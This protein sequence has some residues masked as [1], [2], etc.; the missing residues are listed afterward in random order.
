MTIFSL[1]V[2]QQASLSSLDGLRRLAMCYR[3]IASSRFPAVDLIHSMEAYPCGLVGSWLAQKQGCPHA[4]TTHGT[5]GVIWHQKVV[6]RLAYQ[7]V[8]KKTA[9]LCPVSNGTA[10]M[11]Q[12]YFGQ[13]LVK[14][15]LHP[16]LNGN[17]YT[18]HV[19]QEQA[20]QR[21]FP[22]LPTLLSVGDIKPRKGQHVSLAAFARV[23]AQ[24]PSARYFVVGNY[25]PDQYF[26]Q[27]QSFVQR[28]TA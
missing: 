27:L 22:S 14:T 21:S 1:P 11:V 4:I 12:R 26:H 18:K 16:I 19:P 5:Y 28:P 13:A 7:Q 23:K 8:L 2:T 24:L 10:Q 17:S 6:D 3:V 9:L 20:L 15:T 25:R